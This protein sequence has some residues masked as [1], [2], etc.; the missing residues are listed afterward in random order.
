MKLLQRK[1]PSTRNILSETQ[2][3]SNIASNVAEEDGQ[4]T[5]KTKQ[6]TSN[7]RSGATD[8]S[9]NK[10]IVD[11][12]KIKNRDYLA[13]TFK[14]KDN[15]DKVKRKEPKKVKESNHNFSTN[16]GIPSSI[17]NENGVTQDVENK[18]QEVYLSTATH[19]FSTRRCRGI[20]WKDNTNSYPKKRPNSNSNSECVW[21]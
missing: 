6:T 12:E 3:I 20:S 19:K 10:L 14:Q 1:L 2:A 17:S 5:P 4:T 11:T 9:E 13:E 21:V 15:S 16:S 7:T 18:I 8:S